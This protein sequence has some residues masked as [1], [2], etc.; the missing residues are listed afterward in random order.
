MAWTC[1]RTKVILRI[2]GK[3]MSTIIYGGVKY[4]QVRFA[5]YCKI[6]KQI[7]E[8]LHQHDYKLCLCGSIGLDGG[9]QEGRLIGSL[10]EMENRSV[11]CAKVLGKTLWLPPEITMESLKHYKIAS[12]AIPTLGS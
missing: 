5:V 2:I 8:S 7:I 6:C 11:Y 4:K 3:E 9:P 12:P 1:H 10:S